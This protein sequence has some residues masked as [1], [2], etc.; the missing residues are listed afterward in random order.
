MFGTT[1]DLK[2]L[3]V[4]AHELD[5]KIILDFVPNHTS[6]KHNWFQLS[7]NR[8]KEYEDFYIWHDGYPDE[9]N[10]TSRKPPN[11]WVRHYIKY[12]RYIIRY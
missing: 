1:E 7:V 2:K 3:I 4:K 11:N 10:L 6:D 12:L 9:K 8:V 5:I